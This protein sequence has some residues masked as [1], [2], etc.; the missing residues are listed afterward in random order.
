M[1][2]FLIDSFRAAE[3]TNFK[4]PRPRLRLRCDIIDSDSNCQ[5]TFPQDC[6]ESEIGS[7]QA[8]PTAKQP[9]SPL[10]YSF[11]SYSRKTIWLPEVFDLTLV[12]PCLKSWYHI[13]SVSSGATVLVFP[14]SSC[15]IGA[16]RPGWC[17]NRP[18]PPHP[19]GIRADPDCRSR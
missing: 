17:F 9:R 4:W 12:D 1:C 5:S 2:N 18:P 6:Q 13:G 16:E 8:T 7:C 10:P 14:R 15:S 3:S 19:R 11:K